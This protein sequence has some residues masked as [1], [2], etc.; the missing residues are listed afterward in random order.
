MTVPAVVIL[1][2]ALGHAKDHPKNAASPTPGHVLPAL[3]PS[4]PQVNAAAQ[5][6][7]TKLLTTVPV[8]LGSLA[9]RVV[10]PQPDSAFVVAWGDP[11][12]VLR[13]GVGRPAGLSPG[14]ADFVLGA[15]G[16][17][18]LHTAQ[19]KTQ[20]FTAIDRAAYIEIQVPASYS[21]PPL[22]PLADAIAKALPPV[23]VLDATGTTDPTKLCTNRK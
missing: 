1:A 8:E 22:G 9:P 2:L 10:H 23:C 7:C 16:V 3:S 5:G 18:F 19:G 12:V 15:N 11:A 4:A 17:N 21:Q 6:P 20:V 13:C 14:S